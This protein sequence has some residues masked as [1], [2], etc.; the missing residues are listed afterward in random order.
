VSAIV[1]K[2]SIVKMSRTRMAYPSL[3]FG[4]WLQSAKG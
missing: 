3:S 1:F 4:K 2:L